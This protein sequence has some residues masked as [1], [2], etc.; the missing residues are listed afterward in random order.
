MWSNVSTFELVC[1]KGMR[2]L[3]EIQ[4]GVSKMVRELWHMKAE[5]S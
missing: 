3:E 1:K 2:K 5:E 4:Q